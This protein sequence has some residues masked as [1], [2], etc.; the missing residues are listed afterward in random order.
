MNRMKKVSILLLVFSLLACGYQ[1]QGG[2]SILPPDVKRV[3]IPLADNSSTESGFSAVLTDSLRDRFERFG[4][5]TVVDGPEQADAVLRTKILRLDRGTQSATSKTDI[6]LQQSTSLTLNVELNRSDGS[7]LWR[8]PRMVVTKAFGTSS[9]AVVTSSAEFASGSLGGA[10]LG[11]LS[12]R[13]IARG[14]EREAL[15]QLAD[16]AA[17]IIYDQAVAP[18]F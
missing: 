3:Y 6:A 18:D 17:R 15:N 8:N 7:P 4:V 11:G 12:T 5:L 2:G 13:E 10:D 16:Q 14:Q 1:F 9:E